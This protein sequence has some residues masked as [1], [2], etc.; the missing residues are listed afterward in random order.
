M[1]FLTG[2]RLLL[3]GGWLGA[4]FLL[5]V[6]AQ[7]AFAVLSSHELAGSLVSRTLAILDYVGLG[8][9]FVLVLT[10]MI[11]PDGTSR[12][13]LWMERILL[14]IFGLAAAVQQFVISWWMLLIRT[15]MGRPIDE[16]AMDD[17]LR[18][19]FNNLHEIS[20]WI[21][22][23]AVAAALLAFVVIVARI[24]TV[25]K[26]PGLNNLDFQKQFKV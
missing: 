25:A 3:L 26:K 11:V 2:F 14:V 16:V 1:R 20:S 15:Q 13:P 6:V 19:Q 10:S 21:M 8:I 22:I 18:V 12:A 7:N 4:A 5:I 9:A 24:P 23:T 17:P